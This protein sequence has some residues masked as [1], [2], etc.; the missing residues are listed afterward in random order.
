MWTAT[1]RSSSA[2][3]RRAGQSSH[4][5]DRARR[6]VALAGASSLSRRS[7]DLGSPA[8]RSTTGEAARRAIASP[9]T[10]SGLALQDDGTLVVTRIPRDVASDD[11]LPRRRRRAVVGGRRPRPPRSGGAVHADVAI[12]G[13]SRSRRHGRRGAP[14]APSPPAWTAAAPVSPTSACGDARRRHR[15]RRPWRHLRARTCSAGAAIA[16]FESARAHQRRGVGGM[17][18]ADSRARPA[19][20][21]RV[22][23]NLSAG[24][25]RRHGVAAPR[26]ADARLSAVPR[27]ASAGAR[28]AAPRQDG[29]RARSPRAPAR[30][31]R[32]QR[33][34]GSARQTAAAIRPMRVTPCRRRVCTES[35]GAK[36]THRVFAN[37]HGAVATGAEVGPTTG[38]RRAGDLAARL[39]TAV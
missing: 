26:R 20:R 13:R 12:A 30:R 22:T 9:A 28:L 2:T 35:G 6:P 24:G 5:L 29:P 14:P 8:S 4:D 15:L 36:L 21:P 25:V 38:E 31:R 19:A 32:A 10:S 11:D 7:S 39:G 23:V 3:L 34:T 18:G 27:A 37:L 17:P 16:R 1:S 33:R